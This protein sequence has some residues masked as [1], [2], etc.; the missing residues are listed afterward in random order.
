MTKEKEKIILNKVKKN[1]KSESYK[2]ISECVF[3][4]FV[5]IK[6]FYQ[7]THIYSLFLYSY[8]HPCVKL[9]S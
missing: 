7:I 6:L 8:V 1:N 5:L 4:C 9:T 2:N 3:H